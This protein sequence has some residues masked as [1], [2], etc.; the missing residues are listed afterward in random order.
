M[1]DKTYGEADSLSL[2]L[3]CL[4]VS[5]SS[6]DYVERRARHPVHW[7]A[8]AYSNPNLSWAENVAL[9]EYTRYN[10]HMAASAHS[11]PSALQ[12]FVGVSR[13]LQLIMAREA[14]AVF[15]KR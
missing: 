11:R 15:C 9:T 3:V 7:F 4:Q 8:V 2:H 1:A 12:Y 10:S 14:S 6:M 13:H 5:P